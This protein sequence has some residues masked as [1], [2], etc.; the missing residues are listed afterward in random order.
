[1][2]GL[3][4]K[5]SL[6][7]LALLLST[8]IGMA[9]TVNFATLESC[10]LPV[11]S[12]PPA[13]D[14]DTMLLAHLD[15]GGRFNADYA[16][17]QGLQLG[18]WAKAA[19]GRFGAGATAPAD[20]QWILSYS[21][22]DNI[23]APRGT[24]ELWV[25][26]LPDQNIWADGRDHWFFS[27]YANAASYPGRT[28]Q[29]FRLLKSG[30]DNSL[31][32]QLDR[33]GTTRDQF[34]LS[35][36][37]ADLAPDQ[38]HY[39]VFSWDDTPPGHMWLTVDGVGTHGVM[40]LDDA[41][42]LPGFI[43]SLNFGPGGAVI[44][45]IRILACSLGARLATGAAA[46]NIDL[47]KL[48]QMQDAAR[49]WVDFLVRIQRDGAL[50]MAVNYDTGFDLGNPFTMRNDDSAS[51]LGYPFLWAYRIWGDER[52]LRAAC[53]LANF[54]AR[55]QFP[56]G[57]W[58]Q[59]FYLYPDGTVGQPWKVAHFEEWTQSN[60][61]RYLAACYQLTGLDSY[62]QAAVKA[63]EVI[64]RAQDESG[65]WP[66]GAPAD[67]ANDPRAAYLK[68]PTL[69]DWNLNACIGDCMVLYHMTGD[70]RYLDAIFK[71]GEW[72]I[73]AQLDGPVPG[74][75]A[76]YD[77]QG[78]PSWG[79][80]FEPPAVDT[81]FGTYGAGSALLMLYD[82]TGDERYLQP[83]RKHLAWLQSIPKDKKG[84]M[85][86]AY[87]DWAPEENKA[88]ISS[89]SA[90]LAKRFGA[91]LPS[92]KAQSGIAIKTG[93]PI[94][95]YH[96]QMVPVDYP[97][98]D[99]YL[100]PLNGHYGSRSERAEEW[101]ANELK[102][103]DEMGPIV[104]G[105]TGPVPRAERERVRPTPASCAEAYNADAAAGALRQLEEWMAGT[106]GNRV[107]GADGNVQVNRGSSAATTT[108]RQLALAYV[109]LSRVSPGV[110]PMYRAPYHTGN[111][112][113]V[114]PACDWYD[115]PTPK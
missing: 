48:L 17:F 6:V 70:Q 9:A 8:A 96:H 90:S 93:E 83:L 74:W 47:Q 109:A 43:Y 34:D 115:L 2:K 50:P 49:A 35:L 61:I 112:P 23:H 4:T 60:G 68:G 25:R 21:G 89:S 10:S 113:I 106:R 3:S 1:M 64:L 88:S 59:T 75:A 105:W 101:L 55:A 94:V 85:W 76:Q 57:G 91:Q 42:P 87:R 28:N 26:S 81:V 15:A 79:R 18:S 72:I 58:S 103:R 32:F 51:G 13:R 86:Y 37:V 7:V 69:N 82:F 11:P 104:P 102:L 95:A 77:M 108:L 30:A 16:R 52:Y 41:S 19:E 98:V 14:I 44:D 80:S 22:L 33:P 78:N 67:P 110:V 114:D 5:T 63:G 100:K 71:A 92:K 97:E 27:A 20:N 46:P 53:R 12:G 45:E 36:S 56:T 66:W 38:W 29:N 24:I 99:C 62:K 39:I 65:W 84:W 31:H 73:S 111:F 107:L 54:Y 40:G